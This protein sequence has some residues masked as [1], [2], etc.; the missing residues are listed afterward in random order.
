MDILKRLDTDHRNVTQLLEFLE[1][2]LARM[3]QIESADFGLMR[4]VMHYMTHYPDRVH[5]PLE[6][7]VIQKLIEH[8]PSAQQL[9]EDILREHKD[10][11]RKSAALLEM[12]LQVTDG[13]MVPREEIEATGRDYAAFL[14]SHMEK[15]DERLFPLAERTLTNQDW[16]EIAK[17]IKHL[18]DPVFG[19]VVQ[20]QFR[21][22][23]QRIQ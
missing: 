8:D 11:A 18:A 3:Q 12:L 4:D 6:D 1:T 19:A 14:R 13:E 23:Y 7:L 21:Q 5:H 22:L 9:G 2:Q 10:L 17:G 20:N 16:H 15:E